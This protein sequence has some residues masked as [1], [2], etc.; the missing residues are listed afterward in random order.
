M[1]ER[2][3]LPIEY[4]AALRSYIYT[5]PTPHLPMV[6]VTPDEKFV[7]KM[8]QR[9]FP[10]SAGGA[11]GRELLSILQKFAVIVAGNLP[12][13]EA[14]SAS[15]M[16]ALVSP[17]EQ[18]WMPVVDEA[19]SR[20]QELKMSYRVGG[21]A[22]LYSFVVHPLEIAY[23]DQRRLMLA[24]DVRTRTV[25]T[26]LLGRIENAAPTGNRFER[27]ADF[28]AAKVLQGNLGC[29][30]G[31]E[32]HEV[33]I[34]LRDAAAVRARETPWLGME[35]MEELPDGRLEITLRLNNLV[36]V[37]NAV[38]H[39]GPLAEALSP[40]ELRTRVH[41]QLK[42]TLALYETKPV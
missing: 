38:L 18:R 27:P 13:A 28:D 42:A 25:R 22:R 3:L 1:G 17:A 30:T 34:L 24:Y 15:V 29:F 32:N 23:R 9:M 31:C 19:A 5:A 33:R 12:L 40:P 16:P 37:V 26:F 35:A 36:D 41:E 10:A 20:L 6:R 7:L 39:W 21:A 11:F 8:V 2:L 4:R 14:G